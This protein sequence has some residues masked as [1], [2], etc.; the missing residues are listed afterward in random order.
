MSVP[1]YLQ[2]TDIGS[3]LHSSRRELGSPWADLHL[4]GEAQV[5]KWQWRDRHSDMANPSLGGGVGEGANSN[6]A[7]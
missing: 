3:V 1:I 6:I 2:G 5:S 4:W 7:V